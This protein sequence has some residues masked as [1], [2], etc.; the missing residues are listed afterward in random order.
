[1]AEKWDKL[2]FI[3][4]LFSTWIPKKIISKYE[5]I[6]SSE[7]RYFSLGEKFEFYY[8]ANASHAYVPE[9]KKYL[10]GDFLGLIDK[11]SA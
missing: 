7:M 9:E 3:L 2:H 11:L 8:L 4:N 1:M 10:I 5:K 6:L